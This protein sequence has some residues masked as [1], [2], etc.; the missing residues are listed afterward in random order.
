MYELTI[1]E[2][3]DYLYTVEI[4]ITEQCNLNCKDC[5]RG[6]DRFPSDKYMS[7]E[8]LQI[9][10]DE[11]IELNYQ[12]KKIGIMGGEP[13]THPYIQDVFRILFKYKLYNPFCDI[14]LMTNG[15]HRIDTPSWLR[16]MYNLDHSHHHAY[17]ISPSDMGIFD[18]FDVKPCETMKHCGMGYTIYGYM[19]CVIGGTQCR[20][21]GHSYGILHLKDISLELLT[22]MCPVLCKHCGWYLVDKN[23]FTKG[24][25]YNYKCGEMSSTWGTR[26]K[27][28]NNIE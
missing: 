13:T 8:Q 28:Y 19:P 9:F 22:S 15:L 12:W 2:Y 10:V 18:R 17:Y 25:I 21:H 11:S 14:W 24:L 6:C 4:D 23:D 1:N 27:V 7:C 5:S 20:I 16:V 3:P 26:Y